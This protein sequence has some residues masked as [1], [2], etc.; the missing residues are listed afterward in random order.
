MKVAYVKAPFQ[1][2]IRDEQIRSITEDEVLI[3][4][5]ACGVCGTDIHTAATEAK[6][7]QT[8]GHEVAGI[9]EQV[10]K[11]VV[12][13]V[14]GDTVTLESS[15]FDRYCDN[16]RNGR[17]DLCCAGPRYEWGKDPMGFGE[18]MIASKEQVVKFEGISFEEASIIEPMG[19]AMDL[20]YTGDIRLNDDVLVIGLGPIGLC[21]VRLAKLMGARKVYAAEL[22][23]AKRRIEI[24]KQF[25]ADEIIFTDKESIEEYRFDRSGVDKVLVT[26]PPRMIPPSIKIANYGGI[27]A[28]IG[29]QFGKGA[30]ITFDANDFH[31]KKLQLRASF[32]APAL[33]FPRCIDLVKSGAVDLSVLISHTIRLEEIGKAMDILKNDPENAVKIVMVN[34]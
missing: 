3:K 31:F 16:C 28:Y 13:V 7:W 24:A 12:N 14:P 1:F 2:E 23:H 11:N 15:T 29:I 20:C 27:V 18:Y 21:A 8:F 17:V 6:D 19:V 4:I 26:A 22:S 34:E 30:E 9:V 32:A 10:G 5:V 33:Y 25:G